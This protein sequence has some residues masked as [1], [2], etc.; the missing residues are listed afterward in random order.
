M[1]KTRDCGLRHRGFRYFYRVYPN[2]AGRLDPIVLL[3][4]A[5]QTLDAWTKAAGIF[6]RSAPVIV[7]DLPGLGTADPLPARYGIDFHRTALL[8]VLEAERIPRVNLAAPSYSVPAAYR[9]GSLHPDRVNRLVLVGTMKEMPPHY[10]RSLEETLR[11]LRDGRMDAFGE[12][13][14]ERFTADPRL[15]EKG[16]LVR[17]IMRSA[18][19]GLTP[20]NR[21]RYHENSTRLLLH[22]GLDLAAPPVA[23]ALIFTGRFDNFTSPE[24]GREVAAALPDAAFTTVLR[25]DHLCHLH[26]FQVCVRLISD[27]FSGLRLDG[28]PGC[29]DIEYFGCAADSALRARSVDLGRLA[30]CGVLA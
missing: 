9:F 12:M 27:F 4:G 18:V 26:Q 10:M 5:F 6:N 22:S 14:L 23:P 20:E 19:R 29:S 15:T 30:P 11:L 24:Y 21:R 1:I 2:P 13:L 7:V 28:S 17:R 16:A 8:K 3:T 25:A